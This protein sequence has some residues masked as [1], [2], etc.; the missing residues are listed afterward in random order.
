[1]PVL[2]SLA[3]CELGLPEKFDSFRHVQEEM[4]EFCL[5][6]PG[7]GLVP[8]LP[9]KRFSACG[10]PPGCGKSLTSHAIGRLSGGKYVVLTATKSLQDQQSDDFVDGKDIVDLRGKA[11]YPC[12]ATHGLARTDW[13][14]E[15]GSEEGDCPFAGK[16]GCTYFDQVQTA[17]KGR[18]IVTN[19]ACWIAQRMQSKSA[20][21]SPGEPIRTLICDEAHLAGNQLASMLSTWVSNDDLH[22]WTEGFSRELFKRAKGEEWGRVDVAWEASLNAVLLGARQKLEQMEVEQTKSVLA[23]DE[24]YRKLTRMIDKLDRVVAHCE[25]GNW[26]WRQ[27]RNGVSLEC[28]WPGKYAEKYLWSGVRKIVLLSATLVPKALNLLRLTSNEYYF[29]EWPRQFPTKLSP[30]WW[31]PTSRMKHGT[32][33]MECI[34]VGD[35]IFATYGQH[36]GLVHSQSYARAE[37]L[38]AAC[39]WGRHMYLNR[40][41]ESTDMLDRFMAARTGVLVGPSYT[42][43][44]DLPDEHCR[45]IWIP[46]L[47]FPDK[48]DPLVIARGQDD[49][50]YYAYETMQSLVQA[51]GRGSRHE[52]DWCLTLVTDDNIGNFRNYARRFAPKWWRVEQWQNTNEMPPLPNS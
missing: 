8:N 35:R 2:E 6:G 4:V 23:R 36:K 1:M 3:P 34:K 15:E 26:V 39:D 37:Q 17:R 33:M 13:N 46:K 16:P 18:G 52:K 49:K 48:S 32:S 38:Q 41:G 22:K 27:T 7:G 19:Y 21:E 45:W 12:R 44:T 29:K 28:V 11:N 25:D 43:G 30:V 5:Y 20:L 14:C 42:T 10:A 24:R 40:R 50:E 31:I 9:P 47:P 51:C